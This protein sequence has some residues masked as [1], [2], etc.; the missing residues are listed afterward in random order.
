MIVYT[1]MLLYYISLFFFFFFQAEDGIRDLTVTG[2]QTCALPIC[3]VA[4]DHDDLGVGIELAQLAQ[5]LEPVDALH[6]HVQKHEVRPELGIQPQRLG[7]GRARLHL[8]LLVLEDLP[9]GVADALL[10]VDD[11]HPPAHA[12]LRFPRYSTTPVGWMAT[13]VNAGETRS[14]TAPVE[15]APA[16]RR[17][18]CFTSRS[19]K[20]QP[21]SA[22]SSTLKRAIPGRS[23]VSGPAMRSGSIGLSI[24]ASG[25]SASGGIR[26]VSS[27]Q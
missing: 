16:M 17:A 27:R 12:F 25:P 7:P 6:L 2:V 23:I 1:H 20:G 26:R 14:G 11:Q 10:V 9:Q 19:G 13:S 3:A 15:S 22:S 5:R 8:D 4:R 21:R 18:S 24:P